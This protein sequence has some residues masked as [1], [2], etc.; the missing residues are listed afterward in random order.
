MGGGTKVTGEEGIGRER[1]RS[2][3]YMEYGTKTISH[4][5]TYI[6]ILLLYTGW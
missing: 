3:I 6:Y 2:N 5:C 1:E 4:S